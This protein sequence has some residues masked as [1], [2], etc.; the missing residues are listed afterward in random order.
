MKQEF[1]MENKIGRKLDMEVIQGDSRQLS[2][3][4]GNAKGEYTQ[5]NDRELLPKNHTE[6]SELCVSPI[7]SQDSPNLPY[8]MAQK[9]KV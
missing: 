5:S 6:W 1:E 8:K 9:Q 7:T 3:L 4:L 2:K